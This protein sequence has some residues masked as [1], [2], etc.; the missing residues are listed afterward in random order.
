MGTRNLTIV[1]LDGKVR[2]AQ[3]GQWDGYPT[4]QGE[5]VA[6]FVNSHKDLDYFKDKV[7]AT[8]QIT[9]KTKRA[10]WVKCGADP[11]ENYVSTDVSHKHGVR[12]PENS[13]DSGAK[14]LEIIQL[15][16]DGLEI[17]LEKLGRSIGKSMGECDAEFAYEI[18]L[19]KETVT[20]WAYGTKYG[21]YSF[22]E[23]APWSM[24]A[25]EEEMNANDHQVKTPKT[26]IK[27]KE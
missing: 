27:G 7:R 16:P 8:K 4:G 19:D 26:K 1:K 3:Y 21:I 10:Q 14:I 25:L 6:E 23:F 13:R 2:V 20:V 5:T 12:Y 11:K 18:N 22:K 9:E 17:E 24:E 15:K